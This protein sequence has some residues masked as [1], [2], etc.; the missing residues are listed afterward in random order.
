MKTIYA[1]LQLSLFFP[2]CY[3][4]AGN[5][6]GKKDAV[7]AALY[8]STNRTTASHDGTKS[9]SPLCRVTT[10]TD[11]TNV[12]PVSDAVDHIAVY[13]ISGQLLHTIYGADADLSA[14]PSG[15][16]VLQK[17]MTDG[18]VVSETIVKN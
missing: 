1:I 12:D 5:Q 8:Y 14:L 15:F 11:T 18:S 7:R 17:H 10:E 4:L 2:C 16:Y 3:I 9:Y 6:V 13:N